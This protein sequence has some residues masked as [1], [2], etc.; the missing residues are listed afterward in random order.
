MPLGRF[1]PTGGWTITS[2]IKDTGSQYAYIHNLYRLHQVHTS[3]LMYLYV[4][5]HIVYIVLCH[6]EKQNQIHTSHWWSKHISH[7]TTRIVGV[8]NT[9]P[10]EKDDHCV[11]VSTQFTD[12]F[13]SLA[14][15]FTLSLFVPHC[16][17]NEP[18][19]QYCNALKKEIKLLI[20]FDSNY[21]PLMKISTKVFGPHW[22]PPT[23]GCVVIEASVVVNINGQ[24]S[25]VLTSKSK[26]PLAPYFFLIGR[27]ST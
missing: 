20:V 27:E 9:L 7:V 22:P 14:I 1:Q 15:M 5:N 16:Y 2:T 3:Y 26:C 23:H 18:N 13:E 6:E 25:K 10:N 17:R 12:F 4:W 11:K 19:V 24:T 21:G 8:W